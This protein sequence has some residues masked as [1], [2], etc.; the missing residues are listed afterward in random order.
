MSLTHPSPLNFAAARVAASLIF[1]S[2]LLTACGGG[3]GSAATTSPPPPTSSYTIGGS[4][5]GL[6]GSGLV[7]QDNAGN[8]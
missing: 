3:G 6:T 2:A 7:L 4:I 8:N 5:S 1:L